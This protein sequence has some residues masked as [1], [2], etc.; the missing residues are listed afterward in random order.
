M[1]WWENGGLPIGVSFLEKIYCSQQF[2]EFKC[3]YD[4]WL[5]VSAI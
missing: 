3:V 2:M 5:K 1:Y 4:L